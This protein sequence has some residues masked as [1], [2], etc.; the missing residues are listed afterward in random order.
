MYDAYEE[1]DQRRGAFIGVFGTTPNIYYWA[2]KFIYNI[3]QQNEG[4]NDWPVLRYADVLLLYA[5]ALN[6]NGKTPLALTQVN[7]IRKRAGLAEKAALAPADTQLAIEQERRVELS[8][9]GH[10]WHDLIRWGKEVAVMM[11]FKAKY[12]AL[13]AANAN[14]SVTPDRKFFPIPFRETSLNPNLTQ[15]PGY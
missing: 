7:V 6:N 2:K 1:G 3:A 12:T 10:R 5:E 11:A 9:E 4:E 15:N 14:M 8:F 13:D